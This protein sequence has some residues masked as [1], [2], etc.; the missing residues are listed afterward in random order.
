MAG[1]K[2]HKRIGK[3]GGSRYGFG[4]VGGSKLFCNHAFG[5]TC[6]LWVIKALGGRCKNKTANTQE[7]PYV[8]PMCTQG[9][10]GK[11]EISW[12]SMGQEKKRRKRRVHH[13]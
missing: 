1:D 12:R 4:F 6:M 10:F 13:A 3:R 9:T 7:S 8:R 11:Q 2:N 5:H